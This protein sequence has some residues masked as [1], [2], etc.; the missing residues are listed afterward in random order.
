MAALSH[1]SLSAFPEGPRTKPPLITVVVPTLNEAW[2]IKQTIASILG[3]HTE[4]F[5]LEILIIDGGST[6]DT[7]KI[8]SDIAAE[9]KQVRLLTNE[10]KSTPSALNIGLRE[11]KGE[12]FCTFGAHTHYAKNYITICLRELIGRGAVACGGRVVTR[13]AN[14]SL[15]ARLVAWALAHPFGSSTR[16]FRTQREGFGDIVNYPVIVKQALIDAGGYDEALV[17]NEDNDMSQKLRAAGHKLF[18]T[19][20]TE[21]EYFPVASLKSLCRYGFRNGFWNAVSFKGNPASMTVRYFIP[22]VFVATLISLVSLSVGS[23]MAGSSHKMIFVASTTFLVF[24]YLAFASLAAFHLAARY[25]SVDPLLLPLVF[26]T[27]HC[28]YGTG[29][30][31][32]FLSNAKPASVR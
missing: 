26:F 16:S 14:H 25:R 5:E 9:N 31:Y 2:C 21:C 29:T 20:K 3:Q 23:S 15:Q 7:R 30:L 12:Y 11:A 1:L 17:R 27:F 28:A 18:C 32:G 13:P 24:V 6:D 8:V 22:L 19:W 10:K 4:G